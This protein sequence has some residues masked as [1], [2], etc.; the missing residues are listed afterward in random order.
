MDGNL[1]ILDA[2]DDAGLTW[3]EQ[4]KKSGYFILATS[5]EALV[6]RCVCCVVDNRCSDAFIAL[7]V[8]LAWTIAQ[9]G[10]SQAFFSLCNVL[11]DDDYFER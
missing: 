11:L 9:V 6:R 8:F 1:S 3:T 10:M 7:C 5:N 4:E 2:L